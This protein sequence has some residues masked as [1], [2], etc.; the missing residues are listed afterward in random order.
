MYFGT[1]HILEALIRIRCNGILVSISINNEN[2]PLKKQA[3][4]RTQSSNSEKVCCRGLCLST[5]LDM[6]RATASG[7]IVPGISAYVSSAFCALILTRG[8]DSF[9]NTL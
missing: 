4:H 9:R 3:S 7:V 8:R 1:T 5:V 2:L 6:R